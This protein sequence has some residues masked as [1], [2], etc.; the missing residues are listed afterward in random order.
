M[1]PKQVVQHLLELLPDT[2]SYED[3]KRHIEVFENARHQQE[4]MM[5]GADATLEIETYL[6]Q[7]A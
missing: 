1:T 5:L 3:I 4:A 2:C 6:K 7:Q